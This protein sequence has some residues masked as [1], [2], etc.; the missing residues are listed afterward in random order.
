MGASGTADAGAGGTRG[1][2]STGGAGA[3]VME[4]LELLAVRV[5]RRTERFSTRSRNRPCHRMTWH[6]VRFSVLH[7][8]YS[9]SLVS[10]A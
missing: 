8:P 7:W 9:A 6:F 4:V 2:S 1:A 10:S 3:G 5:L